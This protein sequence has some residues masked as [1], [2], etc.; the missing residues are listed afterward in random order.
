M[1]DFLQTFLAS[2]GGAGAAVAAVAFVGRGLVQ[3]WLKKDLESYRHELRIEEMRHG[4]E[5]DRNIELKKTL[6]E[7]SGVLLIAASDLQDRLWHLCQRQ[8]SSK[9][10]VLESEDPDKPHYSS[11]TMTKRHYLTSTLF[12]FGQYFCW[13]QLIREKV[14]FLD[15]GEDQRTSE[16]QYHLKR[17][18]RALAETELQKLAKSQIST[19]WP[20]F[21]LL[22]NE[23]GECMIVDRSSGRECI[24]FYEFQGQCDE[25]LSK[26][27]GMRSLERLLNGA[28]SKSK[29]NFCLSRLRLLSNTLVG[30]IRFLSQERKIVPVDSIELVVVTGFD[31]V[32]YLE[33][34]PESP[35]NWLQRARTGAGR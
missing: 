25:L 9:N 18:E 19:D 11:W 27:E 35:N 33:M 10:P 2:L 30:L 7:H 32:A 22:Q 6:S 23:I 14:R 17:I 16:F 12:L 24:S 5:L 34:W 13:V 28:M 31:E 8:S 15:F 4:R 3:N 21:Q 29:S 26:T 1:S 20:L